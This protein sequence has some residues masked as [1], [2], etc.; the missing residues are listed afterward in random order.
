MKF[1]PEI[2][3]FEAVPTKAIAPPYDFAAL[4]LLVAVF[5]SKIEFEIL[6]LF[7]VEKKQI[8]PP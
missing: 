5:L 4:P 8:A 2:F 6:I 1:V 3:M 7:A